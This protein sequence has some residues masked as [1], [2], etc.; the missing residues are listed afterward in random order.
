ME[1]AARLAALRAAEAA[2]AAEAHRTEQQ[3]AEEMLA[4]VRAGAAEARAQLQLA[5]SSLTVRG[6]GTHVNPAQDRKADRMQAYRRRGGRGGVRQSARE[7]VSTLE[8][9]VAATTADLHA[10]QTDSAAARTQ[11]AQLREEHEHLAETGAG[12]R[13]HERALP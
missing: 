1:E 9:D 3:A 7:R 4:A 5:T 2:E 8:R 11:L 13:T 10:A 6:G 12:A